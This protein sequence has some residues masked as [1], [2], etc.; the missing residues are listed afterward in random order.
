[1]VFRLGNGYSVKKVYNLLGDTNQAPKTILDI[2]KTCN[3]S[4]QNYF[5]WLLLHGRLNTKDMMSKKN[6]FVESNDC[7]LCDECPQETIM[8]LFF[9]CSFSQSFWWAIGFEWNTDMNIYDMIIG[10]KIRYSINF[11]M[12]IIITGYWSLRDQRNDA[13]FNGNYPDL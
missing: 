8:H 5:A 9:E 13:I 6:F 10:A 1:L 4:R 12:D 3:L 11:L 7:I 2:W